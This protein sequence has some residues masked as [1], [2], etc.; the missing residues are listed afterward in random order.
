MTPQEKK[1]KSMAAAI[2]ALVSL[3]ILLCLFWGHIQFQQEENT[4]KAT[5]ELMTLEEEELFLE[6]EILRDL[7]EENAV[8]HD[9]PAPA[10]KGEPQ[11]AE[12]DNNKLVVPGKNPNPAPP[13]EKLVSSKKESDVKATE[14][15]ASKEEKQQVTSKVANSFSARNG[16]TEG[17]SGTSGASGSGI[18]IAGNANGRSFLGCPSPNVELRNKTT[19]KVSVVIDADGKVISA[20]ASGGSST[21]IRKACENAARSARWSAKKG[22]SE[23][24][25]TITFTI[26][27]R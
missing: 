10:F 18:G 4:Q 21:E 17:T 1:D 11:K 3:L 22:A 9:S 25:G 13:V 24:R 27:P 12:T 6:P 15:S 19:V 2:T 5:P 7:G 20:S 26:T 14:P 16:S 8:N 23:T